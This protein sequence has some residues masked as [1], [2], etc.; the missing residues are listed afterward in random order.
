MKDSEF[1]KIIE[2]QPVGGGF[3]PSNENA[4]ELLTMSRQSEI[5]SFKE[6]TQRDIKFHRCYFSMLGFIYDFMPQ[7]FKAKI[8][9]QV[10]HKFIQHHKGE[11]KIIHEF[12]DSPPLLEYDSISFGNMSQKRFEET[13]REQ[14]PFIYEFVLGAYYKDEIL[15]NIIAII[16][17]E[18][19]KFLSKL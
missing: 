19:K 12:K 7:Q 13:I 16:E 15:V 10:F 11:F 4:R 18:Y 2:L 5:L 9:K 6:V 14:L 8:K 1:S 3:I 17:E